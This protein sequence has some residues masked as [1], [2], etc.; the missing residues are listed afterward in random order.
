MLKA[1]KYKNIH[2]VALGTWRALLPAISSLMA[3]EMTVKSFLRLQQLSQEAD[4]EVISVV[5]P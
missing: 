2:F 1:Y 4:K 3:V 5:V